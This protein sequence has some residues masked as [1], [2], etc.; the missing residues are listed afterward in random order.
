[1]RDL[2]PFIHSNEEIK[3]KE[4]LSE[5][6]CLI[7]DGTIQLDK[8]FAVV[9]CFASEGTIVQRLVKLQIF[10]KSMNGDELAHEVIS[11]L[12]VGHGISSNQLLQYM[13]D[14]AS[15]NCAAMHTI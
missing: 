3:I 13:H 6:L 12:Q 10:V 11:I 5:S 1:M 2:V 4:E 14:R 15:F 8:A 9:L 7:F